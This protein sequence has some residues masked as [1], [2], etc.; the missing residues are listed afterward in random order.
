VV[1][2]LLEFAEADHRTEP[3]GGELAN[4]HR[5]GLGARV[6]IVGQWISPAARAYASIFAVGLGASIS[7]AGILVACWT[8]QY[9]N[10]VYQ[11][12][13]SVDALLQNLSAGQ[14]TYVF[15]LIAFVACMLGFRRVAGLLLLA[16]IPVSIGWSAIA[17]SLGDYGHP[18]DVSLGFLS[19]LAIVAASGL[20]S[21]SRRSR[22][23]QFSAFVGFALLLAGAFWL[24]GYG[25]GYWGNGARNVDYFWAPLAVWLVFVGLPL[26]LTVG[27]VLWRSHRRGEAIGV[28][29]AAA[30]LL[31]LALL[32]FG[33][34][35]GVPTAAEVLTSIVVVVALGIGILRIFGLRIRIT[36][37]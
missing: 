1:G 37:V 3:A 22:K 25:G 8:Y 13:L 24:R 16:S 27:I 36:R 17:F 19:L 4:L 9:A 26:A 21:S 23:L 11:Q 20:I 28:L 35:N 2:T 15:W 10:H 31:P 18:S 14:A 32:A 29:Y 7:A 12:V 33:W 6:G 30:P 34:V 5:N